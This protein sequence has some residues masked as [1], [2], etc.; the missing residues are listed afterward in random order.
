MYNE[1]GF[2]EEQRPGDL[3]G[4]HPDQ[5][6]RKG[7]D[8]AMK[9]TLAI[10]LAAVLLLS[11]TA[12]GEKAE[13]GP[14]PSSNS[15]SASSSVPET[16]SSAPE[17]SSTPKPETSPVSS[18]AP[19]SSSP[20]PEPEPKHD[21]ELTYAGCFQNGYAYI[22]FKDK[23]EPGKTYHGTIDTQGKLQAYFPGRIV[24]E[25]ANM[26]GYIYAKGTSNENRS[27]YVV[28]PDGNIVTYPLGG[29]LTY[30]SYPGEGYFVTKEHQAGFDAED[31]IFH[32]YDGAGKELTTWSCGND[33]VDVRYLGEGIF[34][35][36][37]HYKKL[38]EEQQAEKNSYIRY[39]ECVDLYFA[40]SN[41]WLKDQFIMDDFPILCQDGLLM[42]RWSSRSHPGEFTYADTEGTLAT[43]TMPEEF[44]ND[45]YYLKHR[46]GVMLFSQTKSSGPVP[47]YRYDMQ[48]GQWLDYQ[49]KY[50]DKL[51]FGI[52]SY[53][54]VTA[55]GYTTVAMRGA[56]S[57]IY[58]MLMDKDLKELWDSPILGEPFA[59]TKDTLYLIDAD[60]N[61]TLCTYDLKGNP[62]SKVERVDWSDMPWP[63]D[64][65]LSSSY[66]K[67]FYKT[68]G[69]PAFEIDYS[70]GKLV[71][72]PE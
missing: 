54:P 62:I 16:S 55:E 15:V 44:R 21:Y 23:A 53:T 58:T 67:G 45:S 3:S 63:D 70:T 30:K 4:W 39:T 56:D 6:I 36:Q 17:S 38:T 9:K 14:A 2:L 60:N 37:N 27:Y 33:N 65:I 26:G 29:D 20:E 61:G 11:L 5:I 47:L 71:T 25:G 31:W 32:L 12:C 1:K 7:L 52:Q 57:R 28:G 51:T 19:E 18:S 10:L 43:I 59:I 68:D 35:F 34:S 49:G 69:T 8:K 22:Q 50:I 72:L 42:L 41:T 48:S 40:Q 13:T 46:D 66:H 24:H 64:G